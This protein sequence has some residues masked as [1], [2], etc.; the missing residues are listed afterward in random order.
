MNK[1][2]TKAEA[3]FNV[4]SASWLPQYRLDDDGVI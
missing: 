1:V 2:N 4:Y 3:R